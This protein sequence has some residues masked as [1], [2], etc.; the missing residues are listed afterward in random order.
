MINIKKLNIIDGIELKEASFINKTFPFHFHDT[1][2]IGI[3]SRGIEKITIEESNYIATANK[4]VIVNENQIHSNEF[5]N[6]DHWTYNT[7]NLSCDYL[8]FVANKNNITNLKDIYFENIIE[9]QLLFNKIL[10]FHKSTSNCVKILEDIII[11]LL[12]NN[13]ISKSS[14]QRKYAD[15]NEIIENFKFIIVHNFDNKICLETFCLTNRISKFQ[16]IR[17]FKAHVGLTPI[18]YLTLLRLNNSKK[19]LLQN[20]SIAKVALDCGFYD[21]SHFSHN[22]KYYFGI[23]PSEYVKNYQTN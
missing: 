21:Q 20:S 16:L 1:F 3:I 17:A 23:T 19:L 15:W 13:S 22:F 5:Y 2:S 10:S 4:I 18:A 6:K 9:N 11:H 8:R 14:P 12:I 7:L